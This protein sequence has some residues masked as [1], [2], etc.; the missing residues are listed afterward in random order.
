MITMS[1][2]FSLRPILISLLIWA[3]IVISVLR[4]IHTTVLM[5]LRLMN[6]CL[7]SF[8]TPF[9]DSLIPSLEPNQALETTLFVSLSY[10]SGYSGWTTTTTAERFRI[11]SSR[12]G[13]KLARI[14]C[15]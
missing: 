5:A 15:S 13:T 8:N 11:R 7:H 6:Q 12:A 4:V 1:N 14:G 3:P 10:A 2:K 9:G